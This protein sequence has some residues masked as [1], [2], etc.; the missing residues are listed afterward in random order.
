M[1]LESF[2]CKKNVGIIIDGKKYGFGI[3]KLEIDGWDIK[4]YVNKKSVYNFDKIEGTEDY[5]NPLEL[6]KYENI[7][8]IEE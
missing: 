3:P 1:E 7:K 8:I 6:S 4:I 5:N 2:E